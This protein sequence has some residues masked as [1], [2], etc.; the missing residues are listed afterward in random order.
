[1]SQPCV[2]I[3]IITP[4]PDHYD[5]A[6]E[7]LR[8]VIPAV[9]GEQGCELYAL[10]EATDGRLVF[11]EKWTT[12]EDWQTHMGLPTVAA[13]KA[14]LDGLLAADTDVIE[15]Y[16]LDIGDPTKGLLPA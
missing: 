10:H 12:R 2:V 1:M 9:H 5:R 11:V 6:I 7:V 14:G 15:A 4:H 16:G 8:G 3:A 13:I